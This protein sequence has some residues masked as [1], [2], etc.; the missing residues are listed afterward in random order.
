M[1]SESIAFDE[2]RDVRGTSYRIWVSRERQGS[3]MG[4]WRCLACGMEGVSASHHDEPEKA[5]R[6]AM[7]NLR[8]YHAI[9]HGAVG[10]NPDRVQGHA[11]EITAGSTA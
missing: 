4:R 1:S 9:H 3:L 11:V 10:A 7:R 8:R 2:V 6:D 5:A